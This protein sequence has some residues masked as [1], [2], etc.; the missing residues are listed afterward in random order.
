MET[1]IASLV[2][3]FLDFT[4]LSALVITCRALWLEKESVEK[5]WK[6]EHLPGGND[7]QLTLRMIL[8]SHYP[9]NT[10]VLSRD[11]WIYLRQ[12]KSTC[13]RLPWLH[14]VEINLHG[15]VFIF[16]SQGT[17]LCQYLSKFLK[18]L[19]HLQT[20]KFG[21][22]S[23]FDPEIL[24]R[25]PKLR[26]LA[27][28]SD[29]DN[30]HEYDFLMFGMKYL[31]QL[32]TFRYFGK[33]MQSLFINSEQMGHLKHLLEIE[34][35]EICR[36]SATSDEEIEENARELFANFPSLEKLTLHFPAPRD[37]A[38][39]VKI[40]NEFAMMAHKEVLLVCDFH[41]Y[42]FEDNSYKTDTYIYQEM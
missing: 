15:H 27:L 25:V 7:H 13:L 6:A 23:Y 26:H 32:K 42:S 2:C 30:L 3:P 38:A 36:S 9:A 21:F 28:F 4:S 17:R 14:T 41:T 11:D 22:F 29:A 10:L 40:Q 19:P 12:S 24:R 37:M 31:V 8:Q 20:L 18:R 34:F 39:V 35:L 5:A 33:A 1:I 16:E